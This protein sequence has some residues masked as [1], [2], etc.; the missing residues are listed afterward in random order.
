MLARIRRTDDKSSTAFG[1][2]APSAALQTE[3]AVFDVAA[4]RCFSNTG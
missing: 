4:S 1:F 3:I 2:R